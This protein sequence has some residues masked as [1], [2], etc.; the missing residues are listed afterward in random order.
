MAE[1]LDRP[2]RSLTRRPGLGTQNLG[3]ADLVASH[4]GSSETAED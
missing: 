2:N 1:L 3:A 4:L